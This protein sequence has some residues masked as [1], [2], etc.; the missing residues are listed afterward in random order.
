MPG[1]RLPDRGR[2]CL[3]SLLLCAA[4]ALA[5]PATPNLTGL[6]LDSAQTLARAA[7]LRV[8]EMR[9]RDRV[10]RDLVDVVSYGEG[11]AR[12]N[13]KYQVHELPSVVGLTL[14][15]AE[16]ALVTA[17]YTLGETR[18]E[19]W[20][21]LELRRFLRVVT[22]GF[23]SG[24]VVRQE[25]VP[26]PARGLPPLHLTF[27]QRPSALVEPGRL[28]PALADVP[29]DSALALLGEQGPPVVV[30]TVLGT[31]HHDRVL[32]ARLARD[33]MRLRWA[34]QE[35]RLPDLRGLELA[36]ARQ[37][38]AG[39]GFVVG[40]DG[41]APWPDLDREV[42]LRLALWG[43]TLGRVSS[44]RPRPG[45]VT[46]LPRVELWFRE[47][48]AG[49]RFWPWGALIGTALLVL[50]LAALRLVRLRQARQYELPPIP[51]PGPAAVTPR[52]L[53]EGVRDLSAALVRLRLEVDRPGVDSAEL[54]ALSG[55]VAR[56]RV[57][58]DAGQEAG[59]EELET[60]RRRLAQEFEAL[61]R[62]LRGSS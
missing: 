55:R 34:A 36:A 27:G 2:Y 29:L 9:S 25:P 32:D 56:L 19:R 53:R 20:E 11:V 54:D 37:V 40:M 6:P 62:K 4:F 31:G 16:S 47:V 52:A 18:G 21:E 26:G 17:G 30:D 59:V 50:V 24:I 10:H 28:R 43:D 60:E 61:A 57:A 5:Q 51:V 49:G 14:A 13:W 58:L 3:V 44:Q 15:G 22:H 33:T 35:H 46:G 42:V 8:E 7:G 48:K 38:L 41:T 12:V 45:T 39:S 23:A 1:L